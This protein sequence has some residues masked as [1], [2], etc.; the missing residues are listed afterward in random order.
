MGSVGH[1]LPNLSVK[2]VGTNGKEVPQGETGEIWIKGPT[3]F[4]GYLNNARATTEAITMEGY[5]RTGD[6]GF[7][8]KNG[9]MFIT[10][11]TKELIKYKGS[12]VAP[13]ELEGV[14]A[15]HP[16]V[17]DVAIVGTY[18]DAI[19]SEVPLGYVVPMPDITTDE[20][21]AKEIVDWLATQVAK[22]KQLRGGIV[23]I[24]HI[25]KSASGKILK[26]VLKTQLKSAQPM[27]AFKFRNPGG[28]PKL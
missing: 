22:T 25:P 1:A 5:F 8:D 20:A 10:D 18:V 16:K 11:R 21:T 17:K 27:A 3:V 15:N 14:L 12:Q 13:A 23:W 19:A 28:E 6:T 24:D 7:E 26:R 2:Y 4:N 9:Y